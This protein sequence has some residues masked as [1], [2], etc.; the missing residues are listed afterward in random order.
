MYVC[1]YVMLGSRVVGVYPVES[2]KFPQFYPLQT[3]LKAMYGDSINIHPSTRELL[4]LLD[5]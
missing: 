4:A 1:A 5:K 2:T 3:I